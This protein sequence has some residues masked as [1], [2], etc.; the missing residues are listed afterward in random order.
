MIV[1]GV[2]RAKV[3]E[4]LVRMSFSG[5]FFWV[6]D[7]VDHTALSGDNERSQATGHEV[8]LVDVITL[9]VD[10]LAHRQVSR[11]K[12]LTDPGEE[13]F[14]ANLLEQIKLHKLLSMHF[15]R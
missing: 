5:V 4:N 9:F 8:E 11:F 2:L 7:R 10:F 13:M 1:N 15:Q 12:I 14:V 6:D 3:L